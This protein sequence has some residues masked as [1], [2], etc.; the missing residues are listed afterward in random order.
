M[1]PQTD[2]PPTSSDTFPI[3]YTNL[4]LRFEAFGPLLNRLELNELLHEV[5]NDIQTLINERD[6]DAPTPYDGYHLWQ[7]E[8]IVFDIEP[9]TPLRLGQFRSLMEGLE[10][11]MI[12]GE[13]IYGRRCREATF[14]LL[15]EGEGNVGSRR[16]AEAYI[17]S[18]A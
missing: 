10:L 17:C 12:D 5:Q 18:I 15:R 14:S 11:Y 9:L 7:N 2:L 13:K 16:L 6:V 3:P 4:I 1:H 8:D